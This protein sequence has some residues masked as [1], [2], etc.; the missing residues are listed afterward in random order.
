M[1]EMN[2]SP[3]LSTDDQSFIFTMPDIAVLNGIAWDHMNVFPTF[4]NYIEQFRIFV[5]KIS[6]ERSLI[7]FD[8][9]AEVKKIALEAGRKYKEDPI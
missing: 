8:G 4:E 9:D 2:I 6:D 5:E 1:K 3:Q 7:Y